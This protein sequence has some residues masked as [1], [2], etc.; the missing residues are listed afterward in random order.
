MA[1]DQIWKRQ[2]TLVTYGNAYLNGDLSFSRWLNHSIFNQHH[3]QFRDLNSQHLLAQH[4][5]IWLE[6]LKKQGCTRLSLHSA[7]FLIDEQ[8]PNINVELLPYPHFIVSHIGSK[9]TA[10]LC[11]KELA[12]WYRADN[13]YE[14]PIAQAIPL[15][16]E[17]FWCYELNS[18]LAK[19][20]DADFQNP[21]WDDIH[22]F[23]NAELFEQAWATYLETPKQ[24]KTPY[25]G[26]EASESQHLS[27][28][29]T[30]SQSDFAHETLHRLEALHLGVQQQLQ[31]PISSEGIPLTTDE[32]LNLRHFS[33]KLDDLT[34][35]FIVKIANHYTN[36]QLTKHVEINP[37]EGVTTPIKKAYAANNI[38]NKSNSAGVMKLIVITLIICALGYYFGL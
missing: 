25:T 33:D 4:F 16:F 6:G 10:W 5:Q 13:D 9:K 38:S 35:K 18:K 2:L 3:L 14:Q 1:L 12:E 27:L 24:L 32:L 15:R 8:N 21:K 34:A 19:Q 30:D 17:T 29:P 31:H 23:L 11:G 28:L 22:L 37:L 7:Q 26:L 36:A 20:L